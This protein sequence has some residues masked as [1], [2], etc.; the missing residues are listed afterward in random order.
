MGRHKILSPI[1]TT[2]EQGFNPCSPYFTALSHRKKNRNNLLKHTVKIIIQSNV[3]P[4]PSFEQTL[5]TQNKICKVKKK[6]G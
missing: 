2:G 3:S 5:D 4:K 6:T 1:D